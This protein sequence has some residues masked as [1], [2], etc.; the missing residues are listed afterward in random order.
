[1]HLSAIFAATIFF[2]KYLAAYAPDLST[3][4]GSLPENAPPPCGAAPPYVSTIIYLPV[5][6]Q[7]PTGPPITNLPV[8]LTK[9][10]FS[11]HIHPSGKE[12]TTWGLTISLISS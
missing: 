10:F 3:L 4:L 8:G 5:N 9:K 2:A 12:L 11:S 1:M 7:S 6:P